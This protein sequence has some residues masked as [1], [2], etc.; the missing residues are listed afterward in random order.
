MNFGYLK[1]KQCRADGKNQQEET[2]ETI[3]RKGK[4]PQKNEHKWQ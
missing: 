4:A 1:K 3:K 2:E